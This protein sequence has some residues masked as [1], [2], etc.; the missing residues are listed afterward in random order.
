[1]KKIE[2]G[3]RYINV[4]TD[5]HCTVTQKNFFTIGYHYDD[6]PKHTYPQ[7]CHYKTFRK[8]WVEENECE[9]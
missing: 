7:Y 1:M 9:R 2:K 3:R 5:R 4:H 6:D 8:H